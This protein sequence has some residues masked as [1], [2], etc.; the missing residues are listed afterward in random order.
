[1]EREEVRTVQIPPSCICLQTWSAALFLGGNWLNSSLW[2]WSV[3][4]QSVFIPGMTRGTLLG[5][6]AP[7]GDRGKRQ[8]WWSQYKA[9]L[10]WEWMEERYRHCLK[11]CQAW[12]S[13][14][15]GILFSISH[16]VARRLLYGFVTHRNK[17]AMMYFAC[18]Y[19]SCTAFIIHSSIQY[20]SNI[21]YG[22]G[23]E[24]IHC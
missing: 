16:V 2:A 9:N 4:A 15:R 21:Y 18:S 7:W 11:L 13:L 5:M 10:F 20:L 14:S 24:Y 19:S 3:V 1:M 23:M 22:G 17:M 8:V 12:G 6:A